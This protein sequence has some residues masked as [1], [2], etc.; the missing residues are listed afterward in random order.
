MSLAVPTT[1]AVLSGGESA[2]IESDYGSVTFTIPAGSY[3]DPRPSTSFPD[4]ALGQSRWILQDCCIIVVSLQNIEPPFPEENLTTTFIAND[5]EW[6]VY[7]TGPSNGTVTVARGTAAP[8][9]VLVGVQG[10]TFDPSTHPTL[11][12]TDAITRSVVVDLSG[13]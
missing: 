13:V 1:E 12:I 9:T 6:Y 8:I 2:T 4:F 3:V 10:W 5:I 11:P 7:D